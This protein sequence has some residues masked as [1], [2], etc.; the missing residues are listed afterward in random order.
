MAIDA[1]PLSAMFE[2]TRPRTRFVKALLWSSDGAQLTFV[3]SVAGAGNGGEGGEA[4]FGST[5]ADADP[6]AAFD[7]IAETLGTH[8]ERVMETAQGSRVQSTRTLA[9]VLDQVGAPAVVDFL[10]LDVEGAE[11]VGPAIPSHHHHHHHRRRRRRLLPSAPTPTHAH[12]QPSMSSAPSH[13]TATP[14]VS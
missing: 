13:S 7:G 12:P 14:S 11:L 8:R 2:R 9:S 4:G 3:S 5:D 10:S 6:N 1:N